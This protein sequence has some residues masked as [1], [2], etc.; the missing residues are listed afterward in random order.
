ML[1]Y[2][3]RRLNLLFFTLLMLT[4]V[5]FSLSYWFP[6][7]VLTNL[8]G[9]LSPT[10]EQTLA[11]TELYNLEQSIF[12][13]YFAYLKQILSGNFGVSIA[14]KELISQKLLT[15]LPATVE[16]CLMALMIAFISG[17]P[18]GFLAANFHNKPIDRAIMVF[19]MLG[20]SIPVFWL[21]LILIMVFSITLSWLPS[22]GQLNLLYDIKHITG[23]KMVDIVLSDTPN[24]TQALLDATKHIILPALTVAL[25]PMTIFIRM[26]RTSM[27][28][29]LDSNYIKAARAKGLSQMR[30]VYNHGIRNAIIPVIRQMG[31]N[32]A[33]LVT[34][35]MIAEVI[36]DW[37]GVGKWLI[38]SISQN[39]YT[40]IS[41]GLLGLAAFTFMINIITDLLYAALNPL[42]RYKKHVA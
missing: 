8:S 26:A 29:V 38:N 23:F 14:S 2:T 12:H 21:A 18:L 31:L 41:G 19:T 27:L 3:L 24:K 36:F 40:A 32:F 10:P 16:L 17:T 33:N 42:E 1:S 5:S 28:E 37:K 20:Y 39:D 30:I 6:G 9:I 35:A 7:D 4:I 11:L 15:Y 13:Q 34:L 25:A 22:A